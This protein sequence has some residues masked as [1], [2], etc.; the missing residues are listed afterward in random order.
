[1]SSKRLEQLILHLERLDLQEGAIRQ[2]RAEVYT[3]LRQ[4]IPNRTHASL[5][6][7]HIFQV[8]DTVFIANKA[9]PKV[10]GQEVTEEDRTA[11]VT[12]IEDDKVYFRTVSGIN[13]WRLNKNLKLIKKEKK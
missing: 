3:E 6:R 9:K 10:P 8:N 7:Q 2:E 12:K 13:T 11:T 1:M 4:L 5:P